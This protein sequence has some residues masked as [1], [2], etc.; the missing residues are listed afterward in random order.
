MNI[1]DI[2]TFRD[3]IRSFRGEYGFLSNFHKCD[4]IYNDKLYPSSEHLYLS[5]KA[6]NNKDHEFIRT[7]SFTGL[8]DA[9]R[10]ISLRDDWSDVKYEIMQEALLLKFTQNDYLRDKL[11]G[12]GDMII[13]EGNRWHDNYYG[14]CMCDKCKNINGRNE[15][16]ILLMSLRTFLEDD[17][18]EN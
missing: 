14:D 7:H 16:G 4:I 9:S 13:I 12:T 18:Y 5:Q 15:L 3:E 8:K 10:N 2:M 6:T 1:S 17:K 11:I